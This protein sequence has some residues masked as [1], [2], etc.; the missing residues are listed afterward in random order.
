MSARQAEELRRAVVALLAV[1][2]GALAGLLFLAKF[3]NTMDG[4][5]PHI[6]K[7]WIVLAAA[8]AMQQQRRTLT[9]GPTR[10]GEGPIS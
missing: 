6:S 7:I 5:G 9:A 10:W 2:F 8:A 1:G 3:I 4:D